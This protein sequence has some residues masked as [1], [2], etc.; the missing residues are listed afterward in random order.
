MH[1]HNIEQGDDNVKIT[2]MRERG[3]VL[4][5]VEWEENSNLDVT[6]PKKGN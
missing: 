1:V 3:R 2:M 4:Q 6:L 5:I